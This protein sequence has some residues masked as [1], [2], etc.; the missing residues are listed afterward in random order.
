L[1]EEKK[2][3]SK[4]ISKYGKNEAFVFSWTKASYFVF[5][6]KEPNVDITNYRDSATCIKFIDD[7]A[8]KWRVHLQIFTLLSQYMIGAPER[9]PAFGARTF[10]VISQQYGQDKMIDL[11]RWI[12]VSR[13]N[14][15]WTPRS[16]TNIELVWWMKQMQPFNKNYCVIWDREKLVWFAW[17]CDWIIED[18]MEHYA[19]KLL[20][21]NTTLFTASSIAL[22]TMGGQLFQ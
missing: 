3:K 16:R 19:T 1:F 13:T 5:D 21:L 10:L 4:S 22:A 9:L 8:F 6:H 18:K 12:L 11:M 7:Q 2:S 14:V 15:T 20:I 17:L